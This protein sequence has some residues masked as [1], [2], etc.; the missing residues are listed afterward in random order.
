MAF[1]NVHSKFPLMPM[2]AQVTMT[3]TVQKRERGHNW[4]EQK[5]IIK[6]MQIRG[7]TPLDNFFSMPIMPSVYFYVCEKMREQNK[8]IHDSGMGIFYPGLPFLPLFGRE[9]NLP[10]LVFT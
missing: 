3:Q 5:F 10:N 6:I 4:C 8:I 2:W 7:G 9:N 1:Q